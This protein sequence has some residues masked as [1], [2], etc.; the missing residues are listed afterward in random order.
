MVDIEKS[1][2][3]LYPEEFEWD[4]DQ[5]P[6]VLRQGPLHHLKSIELPLVESLGEYPSPFLCSIF[7]HCPALEKLTL[8]SL[9]DHADV[10]DVPRVIGDCCPGITDLTIPL[11]TDF[12]SE[13]FISIM[14][15]IH[16]QRLKS[17]R[18]HKPFDMASRTLS[19]AAFAR[20]SETLRQIEFLGCRQIHA[21][22]FKSILE[23]CC[24]LEVLIAGDEYKRGVAYNL[25]K[26]SVMN[27]WACT[28]LRHLVLTVF[29][30][31][32]GRDPK[33]L[34]DPTM[35]TWTEKDHDHWRMLDTL[36]T[37]IGSLK[38]LQVLTLMAA[39]T[40]LQ[41]MR[42][43]DLPFRESCLPGLLALEDT[44]NGKIGFLS[45]WAGL[46]RLRELCGS[47]SVLT[48]EVSKRMSEREVDWFATHLPALR[49]ASF[50]RCGY[51]KSLPDDRIPKIVRDIKQ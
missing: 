35:A 4:Y 13:M 3:N 23:S 5:G 51:T 19:D 26:K 50:W 22:T 32:D 12:N 42:L 11:P 31:S 10:Q 49:L 46:T 40:Q 41:G 39:G 2:M 37:R 8:P 48:E 27:E 30:T 1:D 43:G 16:S 28:R 36:Y 17:L 21:S 6:L 33:Y 34:T 14:E 18:V 7:Q 38:E 15:R 47:F 9:G 44:A 29:L 25:D 45:R 20:H 24:A